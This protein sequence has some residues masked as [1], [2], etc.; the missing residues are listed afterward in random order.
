MR[1]LLQTTEDR[2]YPRE[3]LVSRIRGRR[4]RLIRDWR[5][6][7]SEPD[8]LTYVA[9][10]R[11]QGPVTDASPDNLR[12]RLAAEYCWVYFQMGKDLR[13]IF[14]PFFLYAELR[15]FFLCLRQAASGTLGRVN[16][17]LE[18]SL[19]SKELKAALTM[20][21]DTASAITRIE[22]LFCGLSGEFSGLLNSYDRNG[23]RGVERRLTNTYLVH[24]LQANI[25]PVIRSFFIRVIDSR[26]IIALYKSLKLAAQE[27]PSFINGGGIDEP[28]LRSVLQS[29][30]LAALGPLMRQFT[31]KRV[32]HADIAQ[33]EAVLY[34]AMT[35]FLRKAGREASDI[36]LLLDYL[37]RCSI[38]TMNLSVLSYGKG[39]ERDEVVRE[40]VM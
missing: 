17:L 12:R 35:G 29:R 28:E 24:M 15:T 2:G 11:V 18:T 37:W 8:P 33:V 14:Q 20:H 5:P 39:L 30:D 7:I 34:R 36:G 31:G 21:K 10:L 4:S 23:L 9:S 3:Y 38:E 32:E 40:L 27:S 1:Q 13:G 25:H 22:T 16:Q 6:L 19:L 26:N